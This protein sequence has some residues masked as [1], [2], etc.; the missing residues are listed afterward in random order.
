MPKAQFTISG[1]LIVTAI[2][3]M[4]VSAWIPKSKFVLRLTTTGT[5]QLDSQSFKEESQLW[6]QLSENIEQARYWGIEPTVEIQSPANSNATAAIDIVLALDRRI[7]K[8]F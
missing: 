5:L 2:I 7:K 6:Q 8:T 1:L 4:T 3:A